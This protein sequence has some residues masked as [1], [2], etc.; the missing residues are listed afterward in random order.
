MNI[1][2]YKPEITVKEQP[3]PFTARVTATAP[4]FAYRKCEYRAKQCQLTPVMRLSCREITVPYK[5]VFALKTPLVGVKC[6]NFVSDQ[7]FTVP[8]G[9]L[10][11]L[12]NSGSETETVVCIVDEK[13]NAPGIELEYLPTYHAHIP[14]TH[15]RTP[16]KQRG[17][18]FIVENQAL[19]EAIGIEMPNRTP[20]LV[21]DI[22][23]YESCEASPKQ[24]RQ[25]FNTLR[26]TGI[27][28]KL[29]GH[30]AGA[31]LK[32]NVI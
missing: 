32:Q 25:L 5:K 6:W 10:I 17:Y 26:K 19:G 21:G 28:S 15:D 13:G 24:T 14:W 22:I 4:G 16:A 29:Q 9:L 30:Y 1:K 12:D 23:A 7:T 27:G 31:L 3:F 20:D 8:A 18:R 11:R 2:T